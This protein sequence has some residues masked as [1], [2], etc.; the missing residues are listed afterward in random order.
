MQ[1]RGLISL[2]AA[3]ALA[4]PAHPCAI[5]TLVEDG[6]VF[7]G[8]N[9]DYV[10]PGVVWFVP[11]RKNRYGRVNVGFETDFAQGSMNEAGLAFDSAALPEVHW[12]SDPD[13]ETPNNLIERIMYECATVTEAIEFFETYNCKHLRNAQFLFADA[14][15]DTA[16]VACLPDKG[17]DVR[18][19]DGTHTIATNTRLGMSGYRCPRWTKA[20]QILSS[21]GGIKAVRNA[22]DA[23]HQE[24]AAS[25]TYSTIYDLK[26]KTVR[27]YN[28]ANFED[29]VEFDLE[30]E[31]E[32]G[33]QTIELGKLFA[34]NR[35]LN[36]LMARAPR[37]YDTRI[38]L[39]ADHLATFAGRYRPD[40]ATAVIR[41]A[42][43]GP[44]LSWQVDDGAIVRLF[45]ESSTTF[46]IAPDE[47]QV[48]FDIDDAGKVAGLT[49]HRGG[50][51]YAR[52]LPD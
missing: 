10:L 18:R 41:I 24:G 43:D 44:D 30:T 52:R 15:G 3:T 17:L 32:K 19:I 48:T 25:T 28:L 16:I 12:E 35:T 21:G 27:I 42:V 36:D 6:E 4:Y 9:E 34:S 31:L 1:F 11:A 49:L 26:R 2:I 38:T 50:D 20:D 51:G 7:F 40:G 29:F 14:T 39:D 33:R 37:T 5:F 8:N 13:K 45:P 46:R 47:G 22:L 23:I